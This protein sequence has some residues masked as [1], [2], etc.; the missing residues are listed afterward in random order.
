MTEKPN[1]GNYRE[2]GFSLMELVVVSGIAL[3][4]TLTIASMLVRVAQKFILA[5]SENQVRED[6]MSA[7]FYSRYFLTQAVNLKA[8]HIA[9]PNP[10]GPDLTIGYLGGMGTVTNPGY[11]SSTL[12]QDGSMDRVGY[13]IAEN[14]IYDPTSI[15]S[16]SD[17]RPIA[18]FF[19]RPNA[20]ASG[21]D[22]SG[23][24]Y[25]D[26]MSTT[27]NPGPD[28]MAWNKMVSLKIDLI[29]VNFDSTT[30]PNPQSSA[31]EATLTIVG[32]YFKDHRQYLWTYDPTTPPTIG[33]Q[34]V[35]Q[36][37]DIGFR[38]NVLGTSQIAGSG[39]VERL[40]KNMYYYRLSIPT[41]GDFINP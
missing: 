15:N 34:D 37:V 1:K 14:G 19:Q 25:I 3:F 40:H 16:G 18:I 5:R 36:I 10:S 30:P 17:F 4:L 23:T 2:F 7:S 12:P 26:H 22:S 6:M 32:R 31:V 29:P 11:D 9:I 21:I 38:N 13:F 41:I 24:L 8:T 28:D 35:T 20:A 33:S 39:I 27:K